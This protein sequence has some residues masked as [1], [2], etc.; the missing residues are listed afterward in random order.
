MKMQTTTRV[1]F[2]A[3]ALTAPLAASTRAMAANAKCP[4]CEMPNEKGTAVTLKQGSKTTMYRCTYCVLDQA[5]NDIKGDL[6]I[7][8]PTEKAGRNVVIK[9]VRGKWYATP[10]AAFVAAHQVRHR[11]CPETFRAFS[12]RAAAQNYIAKNRGL[13]GNVAPLSFA[14]MLKVAK[15]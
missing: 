4:E 14:Q 11:V 12:N 7:V 5:Q 9:R 10:G 6:T 15:D 1:L 13:V 8:A 2:L 3:A